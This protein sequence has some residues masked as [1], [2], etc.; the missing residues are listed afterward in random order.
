MPI[1]LAFVAFDC[2]TNFRKLGDLIFVVPFKILSLDAI[3]L[4]EEVWVLDLLGWRDGEDLDT[5]T[6]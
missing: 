3:L 1:T 4:C 5:E 6:L 2:G